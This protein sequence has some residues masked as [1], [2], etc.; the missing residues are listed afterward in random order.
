MIKFFAGH[1][2]AA[3]ILMFAL[4]AMGLA[5]LPT[6]KMETFPE[7]K[8]YEVQVSVAYPGAAPSDV[9]EGICIPLERATDGISFLDEKRCEAKD[10]VGLMTLKMVEAGDMPQFI[11]DVKSAVDGIDNFPADIEE[12][13][14]KELGRTD[15]VVSIAISGDLPRPALKELAEDMRRRA[16]RVPGIPLVEV[17]GFSDRQLRVEVSMST[18]EQYGLSVLD[19]ADRIKRQG[20]DLPAGIIEAEAQEVQLRFTDLRRTVDELGNLVVVGGAEGS[21]VLLKD[22]AKITDTFE[23]DENKIVFNGKPAAIL[24]ISKNKTDDSLEVLSEVKAF[25]AAERMRLPAAVNIELTG[26]RASVVQERLD[27]LS[28]NGMQGIVLVALALFLFFSFRYTFWVAMG[29][30]VSFLA[31]FAVM[32]A[33]G[34]SINMISMVALLVAIGILMDDAI[35]IAENIAAERQKGKKPLQAVIDGTSKVA[36]GVL[37][38]FATTILIFSSLLMMKGDLGQVMKVL[39]MVLISVLTISLFE[40]FLILPNHLM[41]ALEHDKAGKK[42]AFQQKFE[43]IFEGWRQKMYGLAKKV[44]ARRYAFV[45]GVVAFFIF[46]ISLLAGGVLKFQAFPDLDGD[47]VQARILMA[48]GSTLDQLEEVVQ[49]TL[50]KLEASNQ[51]LSEKEDGELVQNVRV[52]YSQHVDAFET[53]PHLATVSVDLLSAETRNGTI[54][55][56]TNEWRARVGKLPGVLSI[57][58]RQP[59][60][61]PAGRA[62]HIRLQGDDMDELAMASNELKAW[63]HGYDGVV[64]ILDDLR[65]GRPI[66]QMKL[67]EGA[68]ALGI[69]AQTI[70]GQVRAGYQGTIAKEIQRGDENYEIRVSLDEKSRGSLG[71]F[72]RLSILHPATGNAIPLASIATVEEERSY[73]RIH[74]VNNIR[75]VSV[76][77]DVVVA[78]INAGDVLADV[79]EKLMPKLALKYPGVTLALEGEAKNSKVTNQ[80]MARGFMLGLFGVFLLLSLQFKSYLEPIVVMVAIPLAFI[81]VIWGHLIMG[82][83]LT[84]PSMVGA[85]SLA[86]I[87]VNDSILLV[88][89]TKARAREGMNL[90]DAAAMASRDRFRAIFLT[91]LTTVSGMFPLLLETSM[92]A[93][94]LIPIA[95]SI[96]FGISMSTILVLLFLPALFSIFEDFG[97]TEPHDALD[98]ESDAAEHNKPEPATA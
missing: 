40:A 27:L 36:R 96:A 84:M 17:Q 29:L 20:V 71:E 86:G 89:F 58:Y 79:G 65:A 88:E 19:I 53:G 55:D 9:E 63:L 56:L 13:V 97:F 23:K 42:L 48:P 16:Q 67:K 8:S 15:P 43:A 50:T 52:I 37:S 70:A 98:D 22:I 80:S 76:F 57:Q 61:G 14:T 33:L 10:N 41:H 30:P 83:S 82:I 6:L 4:I 7:V 87:V 31:S 92:Q 62:I 68:Y 47:I 51:L 5:V 93:Q 24:Q 91:S 64:D 38:S 28:S 3:N 54:A 18:M 78:K 60:I 32:S 45:G 73:S 1:K 25:V 44:V 26:D 59:Q 81:G 77:A 49:R 95:V 74:R 39:P 21:E 90:H 69:D 94:I 72:D 46:S 35:V 11:E 2:T 12:P 34:Q 66:L 85:V 75:T